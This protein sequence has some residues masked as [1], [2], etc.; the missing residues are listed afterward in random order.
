MDWLF[1][2]IVFYGFKHN[3]LQFVELSK[4]PLRINDF[5]HERVEDVRNGI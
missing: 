2:V 5:E 4:I 1:R 3:L